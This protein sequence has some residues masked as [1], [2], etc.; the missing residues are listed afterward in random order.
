V[1]DLVED[2]ANSRGPRFKTVPLM[3]VAEAIARG[4]PLSKGDVEKA[5]KAARA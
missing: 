3:A 4:E 2:F 5:G 1:P